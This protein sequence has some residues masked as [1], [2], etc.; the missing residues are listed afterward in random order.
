[1]KWGA[2]FLTCLFTVWASGQ[3]TADSEGEGGFKFQAVPSAAQEVQDDAVLSDGI[4]RTKARFDRALRAVAV[5]VKVRNLTSGVAA[6]HLHCALAG[7]NG[8]V[9]L[10]LDPVTGVT[11]GHIV[12]EDRIR[13]DN[14]DL[15]GADCEAA[16]GFP[17]TNIAALRFAMAED[18]IYVNVHT[19][20]FPG[21]EIRGQLLEAED[22]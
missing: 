13:F 15:S 9:I 20:T 4:G 6:A 12:P 16:C 7:Q 2:V 11:T 5:R 21:G 1:M 14:D 10:D 8:P 19:E 17:I 18:C 3:A 22:D